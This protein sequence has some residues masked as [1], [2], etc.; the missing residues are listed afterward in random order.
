[1]TSNFVFRQVSFLLEPVCFNLIL[2]AISQASDSRSEQSCKELS[3]STI[4]IYIYI[5]HPIIQG[6]LYIY[7]YIYIISSSYIFVNLNRLI[8][9]RHAQLSPV[10]EPPLV[11]ITPSSGIANIL[12]TTPA[13]PEEC[14]P[15]L[16]SAF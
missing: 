11:T 12:L 16:P 6:P 9:I 13:N 15:C 7:I 5:A 14:L 3:V 10:I 8:T 1:M 4:P 2:H